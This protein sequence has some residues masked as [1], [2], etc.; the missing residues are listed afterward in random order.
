VPDSYLNTSDCQN[1]LLI[2]V[3]QQY[4]ITDLPR[5]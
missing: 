1:P 5:F 2:F 3:S 4:G